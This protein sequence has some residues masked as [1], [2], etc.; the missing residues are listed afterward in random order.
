M[1]TKFCN[2]KIFIYITLITYKKINTIIVEEMLMMAIKK[3]SLTL[4]FHLLSRFPA[5]LS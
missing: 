2:E 1:K 5:I 4:M 3:P